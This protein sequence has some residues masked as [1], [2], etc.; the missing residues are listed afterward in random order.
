MSYIEI[1]RGLP[2]SGKSTY[3]K[4]RVKGSTEIV[5]VN[6][7]AIRW[8]QGTFPIGSS[9]E[10]VFTTEIEEMLVKG[11]LSAG[12]NVVIDATHLNPHYIRKWFKIAKAHSVRNVRVVDFE[13]PLEV[14]KF[15]DGLREKSVGQEVIA[16]L[17]KRWKIGED[18]KLPKAPVYTP[19][20]VFDF[21]PYVAGDIPAWSFDIDGTL[22]IMQGRS[23]HDTSRYSGDT[24]DRALSMIAGMLRDA[25]QWGE[26]TF[27]GLSGRSEE[28]H[29]V[30][31]EWLE[32]WGIHLDH[33]FMRPR[34]DGRNDSIVKS[35]LVD[36]HISGK[37]DVIAHFDDR[38]RVVDA[39]RA[40]GMKVLQVA[41]GDF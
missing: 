30:T 38:Q 22:A 14:L 8:T 7:D 28:F 26:A 35:E 6:R 16:K 24:A 3:A 2:A 18:G 9:A 19:P 37:Y 10:E 11:A 13:P 1:L 36:K 25:D 21:K 31:R 20:E 34:G 17:A 15:R 27:I 40:K 23:P 12:K 4:E 32:G 39:L 33:L 5:R 29:D 41:P